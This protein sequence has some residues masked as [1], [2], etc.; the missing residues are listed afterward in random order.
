MVIWARDHLVKQGS[1]RL[2]RNY[3]ALYVTVASPSFPLGTRINDRRIMPKIKQKPKPGTML[4]LRLTTIE[5]NVATQFGKELFA[6]KLDYPSG[7]LLT[8]HSMLV[9]Y[10]TTP[11][12]KFQDAIE[13]EE[14]I[15]SLESDYEEFLVK[16]DNLLKPVSLAVITGKRALLM[17]GISNAV[18]RTLRNSYR[19][20]F[21]M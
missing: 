14:T 17:Q 2:Q 4:A 13:G 10:L 18:T 21:Y 7:T 5:A 8:E 19:V 16:W 20:T 12:S 1:G 11:P 15:W 3:D 6:P 9:E